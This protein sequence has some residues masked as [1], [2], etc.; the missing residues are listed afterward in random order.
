MPDG[1]PHLL[2]LTQLVHHILI[3]ELNVASYRLETA[4]SANAPKEATPAPDA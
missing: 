3:V 2:W 1:L 4:K